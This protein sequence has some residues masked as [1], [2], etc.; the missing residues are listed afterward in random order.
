[1]DVG[2][3]VG[4]LRPL[5]TPIR[6]FTMASPRKFIHRILEILTALV[7]VPV[8]GEFFIEI[9]KERHFYEHPSE[10][11]EEAVNKLIALGSDPTYRIISGLVLGMLVGALL[12]SHLRHR[13][14]SNAPAQ[15]AAP[16][17]P[18]LSSYLKEMTIRPGSV[19][20]GL[21]PHYVMRFAKN[22]LDSQVVVEFSA[23]VEE[24]GGGWTVRRTVPLRNVGSFARDV[25]YIA[26][27]VSPDSNGWYWGG[28]RVSLPPPNVALGPLISGENS[29]LMGV[30]AYRG[31]LVFI[32][33]D[34]HEA[35]RYFIIGKRDLAITMPPVTA[36]GEFDF[37]VEW[38]AS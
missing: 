28:I 6:M 1:M 18:A 16:N 12:D 17:V 23:F 4:S 21:Y 29:R 25:E 31:R 9:A 15:P 19:E 13:E 26:P 14:R 2:I 36:E 3:Y 11:V 7:L 35:R 10:K 8:V 24:A 33:S 30:S 5:V 22:G 27:L 32:D 34:G 37:V 20:H 38:E